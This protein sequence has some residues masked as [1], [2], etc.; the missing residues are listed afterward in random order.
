LML[1]PFSLLLRFIVI[2]TVSLG[3]MVP[4]VFLY[5]YFLSCLISYGIRWVGRKTR[6]A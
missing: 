2:D 1:F 6:R 3:V 5:L 4:L